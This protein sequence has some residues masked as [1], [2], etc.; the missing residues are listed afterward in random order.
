MTALHRCAF[1]PVQI[2]VFSSAGS[3]FDAVFAVRREPVHPRSQPIHSLACLDSDTIEQASHSA[4]AHGQ[5]FRPDG[6]SVAV[7]QIWWSSIPWR[8]LQR[9][10]RKAGNPHACL[11]TPAVHEIAFAGRAP[12]PEGVNRGRADCTAAGHLVEIMTPRTWATESLAR[13]CRRSNCSTF[14]NLI[15]IPIDLHGSRP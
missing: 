3:S 14:L 4:L 1:R 7:P 8:R 15:Q 11:A 6:R 5:L 9:S 13:G 12:I 10:R 2:S